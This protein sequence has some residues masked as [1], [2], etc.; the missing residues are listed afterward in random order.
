MK[1][2]DKKQIK[3]SSKTKPSSEFLFLSQGQADARKKIGE[4]ISG[5]THFV[6]IIGP[7][8][9]GKTM[10]LEQFAQHLEQ[11]VT[12]ARISHYENSS[13]NVLHDVLTAFGHPPGNLGTS[14]DQNL[15]ELLDFLLGQ[16]SKNK[17]TVLMIDNAETMDHETLFSF[18]SLSEL[19]SEGKGLLSIVLAGDVDWALQLNHPESGQSAF[20]STPTEITPFTETET[21]LYLQKFLRIANPS[22]QTSVSKRGAKLIHFYS[23]GNPLAIKKLSDW[24]LQFANLKGENKLTQQFA[25]KAV[26]TAQWVRFSEQFQPVHARKETSESTPPSEGQAKVIL[27]KC[28]QK[29]SEHNLGKKLFSLG[30]APTNTLTLRRPTV[31]RRHACLTILNNQVWIKNLGTTNSTYVNAQSIKNTPLSDGDIIRVSDF[32]LL[33]IYESNDTTGVEAI[34]TTAALSAEEKSNKPSDP[35]H[36]EVHKAPENLDSSETIVEPLLTEFTTQQT[37]NKSSDTTGIRAIPATPTTLSTKEQ[38]NKPSDAPRQ[39]AH[40]ISENPDSSETIVEPAP[41]KLAIKQAPN[42]KSFTTRD[43]AITTTLSAIENRNRQ[44][45]TTHQKAHKNQDSLDGSKV[46]EEPTSNGLHSSQQASNTRKNHALSVVERRHRREREHNKRRFVL[47]AGGAAALFGPMLAVIF[48]F[49][50]AGSESTPTIEVPAKLEKAPIQDN[51]LSTEAASQQQQDS[52]VSNNNATTSLK[53]TM[54]SNDATGNKQISESVIGDNKLQKL[55]TQARQHIR[56]DE[57]S[58]SLKLI[59]EGTKLDPNSHELASLQAESI[60]KLEKKEQEW[61]KTK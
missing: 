34:P 38:T 52:I 55:I 27:F 54:E 30:R 42:K 47:M 51:S 15:K 6:A 20:P 45:E 8:G 21:Y 31:S 36:Q 24:A 58:Q 10:L 14:K 11:N 23:C 39:E 37:S 26:K 33:F 16:D 7:S 59:I 1:P 29:V 2:A 19:R 56:N 60:E 13:V 48:F 5:E 50:L 46:T 40:K 18:Y 44:S 57:F 12:L 22:E 49:N 53:S 4:T 61:K 9:S 17:K 25:M 32:L 28:N 35:T 41:T 3:N 43:E